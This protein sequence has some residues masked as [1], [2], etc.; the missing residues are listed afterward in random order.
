MFYTWNSQCE[1]GTRGKKKKNCEEKIE[2]PK[3][4]TRFNPETTI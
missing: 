4:Q 1:Y 3:G 2:Q